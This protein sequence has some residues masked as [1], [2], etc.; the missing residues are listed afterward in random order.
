MYDSSRLST[1]N[2]FP[3]GRSRIELEST[4]Q[5]TTIADI[6]NNSFPAL[7]I[8]KNTFVVWRNLDPYPH[9][10]ETNP[11]SSFYFNAGPLFPGGTSSPVYFG[12]T[13]EF[14]Y[15]CRFHAEM[16]GTV[17]V[18]DNVNLVER[19]D[20]GHEMPAGHHHLEHFHGFVTGGRTGDRLFMTHTPVIADDRHRFQVILQGSL[21]NKDHIASYRALR[22][23]AYKDGQV[24]TF[25]DHLSL[26]DI[27]AGKIT[28]L[29]EASMEYYPDSQAPDAGIPVP[30]LEEKVPVRIDKVLHFHQFD[31]DDNYPEGLAYLV[32]G[33][34][35]DIFIDHFIT[36]APSFHSVAK[37]AQRPDFW[38][39]EKLGGTV[40]IVVPTK[41]ILDVSPKLLPRV[42]YV[43]NAFHLFWL[44]PAGMYSAQDPLIRR[45]GT[46]P[47]Y[48]VVLPNGSLSQIQIGRFIHFDIRLL[49]N[50]VVIT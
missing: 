31:P 29:P 12:Q 40:E 3:L 10:A 18:S 47:T 33:D 17:K 30:G 27:G 9:T 8:A 1:A 43:D 14:D 15:V 26:V 20:G 36:R 38:T 24:Q 37:L 19:R 45:D 48:E 4:M 34:L 49:N 50:R 11:D 42:A 7:T 25:H 23:S 32:Y 21:V 16:T 6:R 5:K 22:Q 44:P 35:D 28:L 13:G 46:N 41:R 39:N 2:S